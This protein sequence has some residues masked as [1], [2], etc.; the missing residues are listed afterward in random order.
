VEISCDGGKSWGEA[1]L[2]GDATETAWRLWE[3]EWTIPAPG[4]Y[5]LMARATDSRGRVQP[6]ER[7]ADANNYMISHCLP[8]EVQVRV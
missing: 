4:K 3:F 1:T 6:M 2:N 5:T 8:I 7:D